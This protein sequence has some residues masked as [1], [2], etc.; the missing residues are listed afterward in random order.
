[1][2]ENTKDSSD[3]CMIIV[4]TNGE[5]PATVKWKKPVVQ[6]VTWRLNRIPSK[7]KIVFKKTQMLTIFL[8]KMILMRSHVRAQE[9]RI[10]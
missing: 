9:L 10:R 3:E 1:M 4:K 7:E 8:H 2:S 6:E 5:S